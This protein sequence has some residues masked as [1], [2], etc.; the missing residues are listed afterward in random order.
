MADIGVTCNYDQK[1]WAGVS[2]RTSKA[3]VANL[4][5][6]Y[7]NLFIGYSYDFTLS[8]I[9]RLTFG[10]HELSLAVKFGDSARKYRWLDRY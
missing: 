8:E 3:L 1:I 7:T 4:G 5:V 6:R 10:T 9:Q 2:Y